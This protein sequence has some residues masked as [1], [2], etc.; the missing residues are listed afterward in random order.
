MNIL[1]T[2][3]EGAQVDD[4]EPPGLITSL[5]TLARLWHSYWLMIVRSGGQSLWP[6][7][8]RVSRIWLADWVRDS[9]WRTF[10]FDSFWGKDINTFREWFGSPFHGEATRTT[11]CHSSLTLV[12]TRCH[13]YLWTD[14][15]ANGQSRHKPCFRDVG[16]IHRT[17]CEYI[18]ARLLYDS[19]RW[20]AERCCTPDSRTTTNYRHSCQW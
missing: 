2:L 15:L 1:P 4:L 17:P 13:L 9:C 18:P 3:P 12:Y 6:Q 7:R 10:S 14:C 5:S 16:K 8:L 20:L 11:G 19:R